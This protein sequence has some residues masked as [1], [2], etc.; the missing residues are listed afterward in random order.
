MR[1]DAMTFTIHRP[2]VYQFLFKRTRFVMFEGGFRTT[3]QSMIV[4][5]M[6]K[7]YLEE[8]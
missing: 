1:D 5:A 6:D 2:Q 3:I 8:G 4:V 7:L